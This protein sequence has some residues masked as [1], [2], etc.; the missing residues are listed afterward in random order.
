MTPA[1]GQDTPLEL[2]GELRVRS[3]GE[4]G[5]VGTRAEGATLLR[6]RLRLHAPVTPYA[7]VVIQFQDSRVFGEESN[8]LTDGSA[9]QM[10]L[11]QAYLRL[12]A[13]VLGLSVTV[14]AGRQEVVLGSERLIGA[15]GWSNTG[16]SF[17]ALRLFLEPEEDR[18][19]LSALAAT[20]VERGRMAPEPD[21]SAAPGLGDHT[22]LGVSLDAGS[23][24]GLLLHDLNAAYRDADDV[25]RTTISGQWE[26]AVG[27]GPRYALEGA[28][29]FGTQLRATSSEDIGAWFVGGRLGWIRTLGPLESIELGVDWLSGDDDPS[30]GRYSAFNTLYATNH[31]FYGFMDLFLDPAAQTND[32]GL[33][34]GLVTLTLQRDPLPL[35][36]TVHRFW[37]ASSD[38]VDQS[39]IGWEFDLTVPFEVGDAGTALVGYSAFRAGGGAQEANLGYSGSYRHWAFAQL[40]ISF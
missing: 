40:G 8:T 33:I 23:L 7:S 37:L 15:V 14:T 26:G 11:H 2:S 31:K 17:D 1:A 35:R 6:T 24:Q 32:R 16:R 19:V 22:L 18:W 4:R 10:D 30:D 20:I 36:A 27:W 5:I 38:G 28:Y 29:Q 13:S 39:E 25:D 21:P 34:D 12:T 9:N 3:Q